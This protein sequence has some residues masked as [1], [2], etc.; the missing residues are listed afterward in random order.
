M[1]FVSL[2]RGGTI[3]VRIIAGPG[4]EICDPTDCALLLDGQCDFYGYFDLQREN[5]E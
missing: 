3:E 5:L 4:Q 1:V 2:I